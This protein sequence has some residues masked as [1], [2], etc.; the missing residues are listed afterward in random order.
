MTAAALHKEH[1]LMCIAAGKHVLVEKPLSMCKADS[2]EMF[3]AAAARP[4]RERPRPVPDT[5]GR[6][7]RRHDGGRVLGDLR[8]AR[9]HLHGRQPQ[10]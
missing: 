1:A 5:L 3:A 4:V 10:G 6:G 2:E 7:P 8:F 9:D